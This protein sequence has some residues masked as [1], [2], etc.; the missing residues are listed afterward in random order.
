MDKKDV[1]E[2]GTQA[3]LA[4]LQAIDNKQAELGER[5]DDLEQS[6]HGEGSHGN[7]I[8]LANFYF[9]P[10]DKYLPDMSFISP[11]AAEP[12][13]EAL[14]LSLMTTE[15][16]RTGKLCLNTSLIYTWLHFQR[17]VRGRLLGIGA[18]AM[19]E[20]VSNESTREEGLAEFDAGRE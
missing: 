16:A 3:I 5:L 15:E 6:V 20:Q 8:K 14:T 1:V 2:D 10:E 9:K 12:L 17:G 18:E 7:L 19:R 11:L 4:A 13:A